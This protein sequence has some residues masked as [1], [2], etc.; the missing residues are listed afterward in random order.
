[1][2]DQRA[3][4]QLKPTPAAT[5][6]PDNSTTASGVCANEG[7]SWQNTSARPVA[8]AARILRTTISMLQMV[9]ALRQPAACHRQGKP[10]LPDKPVA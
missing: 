8:T 5:E 1:M 6:P 3:A 9:A 7:V 10:T 2:E 4:P